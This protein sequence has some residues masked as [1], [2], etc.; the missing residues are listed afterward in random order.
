MLCNGDEFFTYNSKFKAVIV[1][2]AQL[3]FCYVSAVQVVI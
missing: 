3:D 1:L 2:N